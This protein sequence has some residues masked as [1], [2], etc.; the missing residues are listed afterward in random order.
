[1]GLALTVILFIA[2]LI[3]IVK[4]GDSFVDSAVWIAEA[5][6]IPKF[7]IGATIVSL[8]TTLPEVIVSALAAAAGK[9]D[10]AIGNA[11]GSVTANTGLILGISLFFMPAPMKRAAFGFKAILMIV[12]TAALLLLS[13]P[14][15]GL[16]LKAGLVLWGIL[17]VYIY[18]S[19]HTA[20]QESAATDKNSINKKDAL[21]NVLRFI[22]GAAGIVVGAR[23]LVNKG[24]DLAV[25]LGVPDSVV[26]LTMMAVGTAL[27]ELV[28][29]VTAIRKKQSSLS[30]G[31]I[32]G[33]NI[34]DMTLILPLC[35]AAYGGILPM[36]RQTLV[37]DIPASLLIMSVAIIPALV[38][39][40]FRRW[41][42][43]AM[44]ALYCA[45]VVILVTGAI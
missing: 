11:I 28:T 27:P 36:T 26:A 17:A 16:S 42:G 25:F 2:G 18:E 31:N 4:G 45:Y 37:L 22:L 34:I 12:A 5:T 38:H 13:L 6:G 10:M 44:L 21:P 35:S 29:T 43:C 7:I 14:A 41:Q 8:A 30:V 19:I 33:A 1:M 24:S 40:R 20:K 15:N 3:L 32:I 9:T 23:L 39:E